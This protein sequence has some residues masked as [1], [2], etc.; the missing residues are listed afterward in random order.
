MRL[1]RQKYFVLGYELAMEEMDHQGHV[2]LRAW[3]GTA[4][5]KGAVLPC[6][7]P[8]FL[9][10]ISWSPSHLGN[11]DTMVKF[12]ILA[13]SLVA[14]TVIAGPLPGPQT[15]TESEL[16]P[17][18][19]GYYFQ[20]W[21][22]GGSNIRCNNGGGGSYTANWNSKGGFVCGKGWSYGGNR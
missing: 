22:E 21:S 19:G 18:Q 9:I 20:N 11:S 10:L 2:G 4:A 1:L 6:G 8:G 3:P 5:Y 7:D 12:S 15:R 14:P 13:A 16:S 17:R